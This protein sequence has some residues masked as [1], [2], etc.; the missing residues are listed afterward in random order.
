MKCP[1]CKTKLTCKCKRRTASNGQSCCSRCIT[2]YET[3]LKIK[4]TK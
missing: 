2:R 3:E 4:Q 1:T